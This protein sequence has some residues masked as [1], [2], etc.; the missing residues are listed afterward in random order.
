MK[1]RLFRM[2]AALLLAGPVSVAS[3]SHGLAET[4]VVSSQQAQ[5]ANS[6]W[7]QEWEKV[8]A[9]AKKEGVVTVAGPPQAAERSAIETFTKAYPGIRLKYTGLASGQF[10]SR[11]ALEREGGVHEWD[12][13]VGGPTSHYDYIKKGYFQPIRP[14]LILP[15]VVDD[16]T[17]IGGLDA[18][19]QDKDK[20][21]VY[22]FTSYIDGQIRVNRTVVPQSELNSAEG[23]LDP[24]WRGKIVMY[25][26]RGSGAG[27]TTMSMLRKELGDEAMKILLV[28]Q[29]PVLS[30]D[31]RQFT[32]WVIR[33]QY[34]IGIGIVDPYLAPFLEQG[35]GKDV[36]RL[37]TKLKLVTTGSG[38]LVIMNRNPHPNATKVFVNW[39]LSK[40][41]QTEWANK[42]DTNSRRVD[43]P[44]GSMETRPDPK[45]LGDYL[46]FNEEA[47]YD[48]KAETQEMLRRIRP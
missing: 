32:E 23:L 14:N 25:D 4:P 12:V 5:S 47:N 9:A 26:P 28:D 16:A 39:L 34:P 24:K 48:F 29:K 31:K 19:F 27:S 22:A 11:V 10:I 36:G 15:E 3:V 20:K 45:R 38:A 37:E 21:Y 6:G 41:A 35:V 2:S 40:E 8:L 7:A 17:W 1:G 42:A 30:T 43:V 44:S 13:A 33:G 46:N 18:G